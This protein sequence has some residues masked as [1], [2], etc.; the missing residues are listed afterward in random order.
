MKRIKIGVFGVGRGISLAKNMMLCNA[1]IVALCD[2]N[3]ERMAKAVE[4]IGGNVATYSDFD[5]F[6]EH[7]LDAVILARYIANWTGYETV[8]LANNE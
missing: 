1:D 3:E 7:G 5:S 8:P 4:K 2:N 6:I